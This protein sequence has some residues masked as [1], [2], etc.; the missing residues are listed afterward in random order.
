LKTTEEGISKNNI[1]SENKKD[2]FGMVI[3]VGRVKEEQ[4]ELTV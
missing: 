3:K 1:V 4:N 2:N